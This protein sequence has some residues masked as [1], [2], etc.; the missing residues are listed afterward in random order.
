MLSIFDPRCLEFASAYLGLMRKAKQQAGIKLSEE[1]DAVT[2]YGPTEELDVLFITK[3][4]EDLER[5][6]KA[7]GLYMQDAEERSVTIGRP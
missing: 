3:A 4:W 2:L 1:V 6:G 7:K 5:A